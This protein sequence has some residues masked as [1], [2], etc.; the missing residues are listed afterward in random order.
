LSHCTRK[1]ATV[2]D[3]ISSGLHSDLVPR[4]SERAIHELHCIDEILAS[5]NLTEE[6]DHR[7]SP[8]SRGDASL[9][10]GCI[11]QLLKARGQ[12]VDERAKSF[13]RSSASTSSDVH[14]VADSAEDSVPH[15]AAPQAGGG[16]LHM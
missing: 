9:D 14:V 13:G 2:S 16:G 8:F 1:D 5:T 12:A 11:Y 6:P 3:V 10:S 4:L 7:L 15:G